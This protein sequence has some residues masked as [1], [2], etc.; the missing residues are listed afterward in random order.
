MDRFHALRVF[1]QVA[2]SGGFAAAARTLSMSPPAVTRAIALLEDRLGTRLFV[3]T[4]RSVRLTQSGQRFLEDSARILLDLEEAEAA[5]IGAHSA[6]RGNLRV[7]APAMF[8]RMHIAP[9]LG[10]FLGR[11]PQVSCE[12][13]FI[14]RVVNIVEEGFDA[15]IRI[16]DLPD[17]SL[18][19]I[20][21]G[22][23]RHVV[24]ASPR[25]L[26]EHGTP[27]HPADLSGYRLIHAAATGAA[28]AWSFQDED[29]PLSI[30]V[31]ARL[32]M[33]TNDAV[34]ELALRNWGIAR[35]LSYQIA[36][37]LAAQNLSAILTSF[38]CPP[39]PVHVIHPEGRMVSARVRAF[40]DIMV[41]RLR[42]DLAPA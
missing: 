8:G 33:N 1:G 20:R 17:S 34:I 22:T 23:V 30:P 12:T 27:K 35:L 18:T 26:E 42:A 13:L 24:F 40:I 36:P 19:A 10:D 25:Y 5:A 41:D 3:R 39:V 32:H 11:Y 2:Q 16:G 37:H 7:T 21:V 4:T 28:P 14:D 6:P 9:I 31:D 29:K 38:E 15:A